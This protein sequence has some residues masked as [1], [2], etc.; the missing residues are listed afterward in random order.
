MRHNRFNF[1]FSLCEAICIFT[2]HY[3]KAVPQQYLTKRK[4]QMN[5]IFICALFRSFFRQ[6]AGE[7]QVDYVIDPGQSLC[8]APSWSCTTS[9]VM[10][11]KD[12]EIVFKKV[13]AGLSPF[14]C[15]DFQMVLC[16]CFLI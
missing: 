12:E 9:T 5:F 6:R 3:T 1:S 8:R 15:D 16:L 4:L 10:A 2:V 14:C 13:R 7:A 11:E